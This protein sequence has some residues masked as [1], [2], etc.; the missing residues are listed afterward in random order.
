MYIVT[1][2][3]ATSFR[4]IKLKSL[5]TKI[6]HQSYYAVKNTPYHKGYTVHI[7]KSNKDVKETNIN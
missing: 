6:N 2:I 1:K 7:I 3:H 5:K 4:D